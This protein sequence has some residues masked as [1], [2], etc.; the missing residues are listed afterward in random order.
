MGRSPRIQAPNILFHV[1]NRGN[2]KN[3]IFFTNSDYIEYRDTMKFYK[4][5]FAVKLY[6]YVLM[7]N[8][9]HFLIEPL[10]ENALSAFMQG[11]TIT[12]TKRF[13]VRHS[14]VG[15]IWQG[16]FKSI[17]IETDA[18]FLQCGRYIEL[19]P[20]R[21]NISDHPSLYPWSSYHYYS[22]GTPDPLLD[23]YPFYEELGSTS[24]ERQ[25]RYSA[26]IEEEMPSI[27]SKKSM[28]FS[29]H[30]VYGSEAFIDRLKKDCNFDLLRPKIGRPRKNEA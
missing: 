15:H 12:H 22:K 20:V 1:I 26:F 9:I 3:K 11:L 16:R 30:Q 17:P 29:E 24:I 5:K 23:T 6:H 28:R 18:Y 2:G 8:H 13:H 25:K 21:A 19:N 27:E 10:E 4:E 14:T 7:S